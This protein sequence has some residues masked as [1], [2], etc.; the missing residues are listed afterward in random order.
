MTRRDPLT[1]RPPRDRRVSVTAGWSPERTDKKGAHTL[2]PSA[3]SATVTDDVTAALPE[4]RD[5][6][7]PV[8]EV[9][10]S[11]ADH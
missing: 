6:T 5:Q 7:V 3:I 2:T 4:S 1:S 10:G 9:R 11:R 8:T